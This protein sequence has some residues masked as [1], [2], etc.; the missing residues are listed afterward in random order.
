MQKRPHAFDTLYTQM[1]AAGEAG[2]ILDTILQRLSTYIEKQAKLKSQVR[3]AMVY[4]IAVLS[5]AAIV[6]FV[7]LWQAVPTFT[8]LFEGLGAEL[9]L[10]TRI[11]IWASKTLIVAVPF[12]LGAF[13]GASYALR[14]YYATTAGRLRIDGLLLK[15][16]ILGKIFRKIAV[17]RFCRTLGTL[18]SSGVPIL[19]G[20][21]ITAKTA[22]NAV[23]E[24]AI[25]AVRIA[26]R[27][28]RDDRRAAQGHRRVS[29]RWW[30]R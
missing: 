3:A 14:R 26:H 30:R 8:V 4:P 25:L 17:A 23:I 21:D 27:A 28:R 12:L 1:I 19:D 16:P 15:T 7:I 11:V 24:R 29:A 2:G 10:A 22:G 13:V 5:I 6:V 9:P 18:I 20:L